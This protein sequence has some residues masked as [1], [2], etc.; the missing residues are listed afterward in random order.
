M[1]EDIVAALSPPVIWELL[2][3]IPIGDN[4]F[5][6]M[7]TAVEG[8]WLYKSDSGMTFVPKKGKDESL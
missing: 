8:G 2:S 5:N 7:R 1:P 3:E 4:H 6:L